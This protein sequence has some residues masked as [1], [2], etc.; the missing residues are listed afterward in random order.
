MSLDFKVFIKNK[1]NIYVNDI[2]THC[3]EFKH[4]PDEHGLIW[5]EQVCPVYPVAQ[6]QL[7]DTT[8]FWVNWEQSAPFKHGPEAHTFNAFYKRKYLKNCI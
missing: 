4:G 5:T 2:G 1:I 8:P 6:M 3:P 7:K